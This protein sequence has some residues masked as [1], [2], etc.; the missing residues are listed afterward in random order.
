MAIRINYN[1]C[2][3]SP[4]CSGMSV[5][6]TGTIF[7]DKETDNPRGTKGTLCVNNENCISC[8][9][10]V[11]AEGCPIGAINLIDHDTEMASLETDPN[12]VKALF[13]ERYGAE[14]VDENVCIDNIDDVLESNEAITIIEEFTDDSIQCLLH[15]IP[16]DSIISHIMKI[17]NNSDIVYYKR[18][19]EDTPEAVF[20][21]LKIY[22]GKN[23]I[24]QIE[25]YYSD[26]QENQLYSEIAKSF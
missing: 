20:P 8:G 24:S 25:G 21:R 4:E 5:C 26:V 7:W 14:P 2:D 3:N 18:F 12:Q 1:I 19:M 11:G 9:L 15:S 10:C 22:K 13:V 16:I 6:P 23:M 17:N